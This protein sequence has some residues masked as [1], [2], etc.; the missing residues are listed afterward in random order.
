[1]DRY[2]QAPRTAV[3]ACFSFVFFRGGGRHALSVN[4]CFSQ[5]LSM[6]SVVIYFWNHG[7]RG[8]QFQTVKWSILFFSFPLD[9]IGDNYNCQSIRFIWH[10]WYCTYLSR[11]L[12]VRKPTTQTCGCSALVGITRCSELGGLVL[13]VTNLRKTLQVPAQQRIISKR[14]LHLCVVHDS[15]TWPHPVAGKTENCACWL[16]TVWARLLNPFWCTLSNGCCF[17]SCSAYDLGGAAWS[18]NEGPERGPC[19]E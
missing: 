6:L 8:M 15:K 4:S 16:F 12:L 11:V 7:T 19:H 10:I 9:P 18:H 2:L 13:W 3:Q 17:P 5:C 14:H 1:M